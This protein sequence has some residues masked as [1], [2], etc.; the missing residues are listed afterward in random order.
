MAAVKGK[1]RIAFGCFAVCHNLLID[2]LVGLRG[3]L[4]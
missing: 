4:C 1:T 2:G 3:T